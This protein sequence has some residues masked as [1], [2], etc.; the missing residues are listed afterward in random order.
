MVPHSGKRLEAIISASYETLLRIYDLFMQVECA[1]KDCPKN[2]SH[3][4]ARRHGP[5]Q[6][7]ARLLPLPWLHKHVHLQHGYGHHVSAA[8]TR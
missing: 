3:C 5:P 4:R 2:A 8:D 1:S 6:A 7:T